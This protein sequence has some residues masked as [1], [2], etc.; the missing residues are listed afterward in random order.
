MALKD[1]ISVIISP[2][3]GLHR[4][5]ET[6]LSEA[7]L[8]DKVWS[9]P[10][11]PEPPELQHLRE[12]PAGTVLFLDF[13]DPLRAR[14]VAVELDQNYP[15]VN[16][17]AVH[18]GES[19]DELRSLMKLGIRET[20][21]DPITAA[22]VATAI[23]GVK[24]RLRQADSIAA[25]LYAFLPSKPGVGCTTVAIQTAWAVARLTQ[26]RTLLLDFDLQ[27]GITSF[28]MKLDGRHSVQDALNLAQVLDESRW[29][30]LVCQRHN[31]D[32]LGS[33]PPDQPAE[34]PDWASASVLDHAQ[35]YYSTVCVDLPGTMAPHEVETLRRAEEIFLV[36]NADVAGIHLAKRKAEVL[37]RLNVVERV[38]VVLNRAERRSALRLSDIEEFLSLPVRFTIPGDDKAVVRTVQEG[39]PLPAGSAMAGQIDALA[40]RIAGSS[41]AGP[42]SMTQRFVEYFSI[43]PARKRFSWKA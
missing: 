4:K 29:S 12:A 40:R 10:D 42:G 28:L 41:V 30:G 35:K 18:N 19:R 14:R 15:D 5:L 34:P 23:A 33:A 17:V 6:A 39:G 31:L 13:S 2:D 20:V 25:N 26:R 8:A 27:L 37:A 43:S 1:C 36:C 9:V 11:Y 38:A 3:P 32:V 21:G 7:A 16:V 24:Q 22:A